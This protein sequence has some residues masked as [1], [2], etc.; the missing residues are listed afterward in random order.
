MQWHKKLGMLVVPFPSEGHCL[1]PW[2][3]PLVLSSAVWDDA[4]KMKLFF[5]TF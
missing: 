3:S 4:G 2:C 5:Q 1:G